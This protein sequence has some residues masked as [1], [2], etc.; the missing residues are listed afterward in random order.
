[1][2]VWIRDNKVDFEDLPKNIIDRM[3]GNLPL[4]YNRMD[5]TEIYTAAVWISPRDVQTNFTLGNESVITRDRDDNEYINVRLTSGRLYG[6]FYYIRL[7]SDTG[8]VVCNTIL[9]Y[10]FC[11]QYMHWCCLYH[12]KCFYVNK[13]GHLLNLFIL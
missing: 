11:V 2:V 7:N 13:S 9:T 1:V 12:I 3:N 10:V 6:V 4:P 8:S 5:N